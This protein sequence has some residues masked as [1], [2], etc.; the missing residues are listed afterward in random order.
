ML[1]ILAV[2]ALIASGII[3]S[4]VSFA[5]LELHI[6][7]A[8]LGF[9]ILMALEGSG[10]WFTSWFCEVVANPLAS[11]APIVVFSIAML[12]ALLLFGRM[13]GCTFARSISECSMSLMVLTSLV[14]LIRFSNQVDA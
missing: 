13:M 8:N 9:Q 11:V 2:P 1:L 6:T 14:L 4:Q 5:L 3:N 12:V 7:L 10:P